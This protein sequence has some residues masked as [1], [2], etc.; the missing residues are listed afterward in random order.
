[1]LFTVGAAGTVRSPLVH[2]VTQVVSKKVAFFPR[3]FCLCFCCCLLLNWW[4][5]ER[6]AAGRAVHVTF[7]QNHEQE[8]GESELTKNA[9]KILYAT[10]EDHEQAEGEPLDG[11][12]AQV[13]SC[14][15]CAVM[16][17]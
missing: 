5:F 1:M 17:G 14:V 9:F 13:T 16:V 8:S 10:D 15:W 11:D 6:T 4:R 3:P 2:Y 12:Q 7:R